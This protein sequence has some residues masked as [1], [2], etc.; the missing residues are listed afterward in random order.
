MKKLASKKGFTLVETLACVITLVLVSMICSTGINFALNV[1][2]E[3][4]F[5][6]ESQMLESTLNLYLGD[7]LRH[8]AAVDTETSPLDPAEPD[9][10]EVTSFTNVAYQIYDGQIEVSERV[11][12]NGGR[13]MI[14]RKAGV[15]SIPLVN[16]TIYDNDMYV[17]DF[18]LGYNEN[19][20]MFYG[21]FVI[22]SSLSDDLTKECTFVYRTI[23]DIN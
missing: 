4:V 10:K 11:G 17:K 2:Q 19:T 3:S 21:N 7:I 13:F 20:G 8:A 16:G 12:N 23:A 22:K 6:S 9:V 5:E 14:Y 1:Y 15:E 18:V